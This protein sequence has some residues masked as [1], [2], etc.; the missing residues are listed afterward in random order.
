[1][2]YPNPLTQG[3]A[4]RRKG[5]GKHVNPYRGFARFLFWLGWIIAGD[6]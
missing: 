4:C 1:M 5:Y 6:S 3:Q 2:I